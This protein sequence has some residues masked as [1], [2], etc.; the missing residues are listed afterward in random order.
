MFRKT[1]GW[2]PLLGLSGLLIRGNLMAAQGAG[3]EALDFTEM[4]LSMVQR[5]LAERDIRDPRVLAAMRKVERHLFVPKDER[6]WAYEDGPL[7]IG[8]GQTISQPFIVALM[9]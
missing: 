3:R 7:S 4:R 5:Q 9:T 2:I 1:A 8:Y 6:R